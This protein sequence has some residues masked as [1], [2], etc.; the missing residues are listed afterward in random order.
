MRRMT[1]VVFKVLERGF[2]LLQCSLIDMKIEFGVNS[3]GALVLADVID[4][5][6]WRVWPNGD[7]RLQ[8][9]KQFYR[10]LQQVTQDSLK[11]L[12]SN[13]EKVG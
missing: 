9:D 4:N 6:S 7:K 2:Q 8:L 3:E 5:D 10:E 11:E 1:I 13:Y 12:L